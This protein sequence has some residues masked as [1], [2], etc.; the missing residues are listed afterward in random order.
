LDAVRDLL[1]AVR[2]LDVDHMVADK[3]GQ[4]RA[5]LLDRGQPMPHMDLHIA[6]TAVVHGLTLVTHNVRHFLLVPELRGDD[7]LAT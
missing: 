4:L 7:W 1:Q 6:A 3:A 2:F 5:M